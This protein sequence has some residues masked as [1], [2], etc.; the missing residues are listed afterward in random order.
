MHLLVLRVWIKKSWNEVLCTPSVLFNIYF[1]NSMFQIL[2]KHSQF[3]CSTILMLK[4]S[5][6]SIRTTD[7]R[8]HAH[9]SS[10]PAFPLALSPGRT[11]CSRPNTSQNKTL[12]LPYLNER[13]IKILFY[14]RTFTQISGFFLKWGMFQ[15][16][17]REN[18]ST[19][20]MCNNL[21]PKI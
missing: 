6:T 7:T 2:L 16:G 17:C 11:G 21:L 10:N 8:R 5:S 13:L 9:T 4:N 14:N 12:S 18:Q 3:V 20:F 1:F 15:I 19:I